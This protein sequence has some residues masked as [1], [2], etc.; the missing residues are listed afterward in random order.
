MNRSGKAPSWVHQNH[1]SAGW[2]TWPDRIEVAAP[3][4]LLTLATVFASLDGEPASTYWLAALAAAW[5][6]LTDTLGRAR[7]PGGRLLPLV[8]FGGILVIASVLMTH[9]ILFLVFMI[10][11]FFH[12]LRLEPRWLRLAGLVITAFLL[13]GLANGGLPKALTTMPHVFLTVVLVQSLTIWGGSVMADKIADQN[14]ARKQALA[15]LNAAMAENAGLHRQLLVQA[16]EA[17]VLDERQRLS[18]EIHDTLA[19]G[20]AGII[21]Q[22]QAA[23]QADPA[24]WRRHVDAALALARENL[25]EA[26]R[27]VHALAPEALDAAQLPDALRG[28]ARRWSDRTGVPIEFTTTGNSRPV[29]PEIEA[30]LL[31]ITQEALS[32][33][34]KHAGAGRVGLTLSYMEEQVTLD[35]RDDGSGFDTSMLPPDGGM[36][37]GFGIAGMRHRAQ[38]LAG[39][40]TVEAEPGGGTAV[41]VNLPAIPVGSAL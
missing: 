30:T 37:G 22:L 31:R 38:R 23:D 17:G 2:G 19:Q 26:R 8:S 4:V 10:I 39:T 25:T 20:F 15:E 1:A 24:V 33:V 14:N 41:S 40:L 5:V 32:N 12:A 7:W 9:D 13:H 3:Y 11:G 27:S 6:A 34:A 35:V 21:T 28:V 18:R 36:G 16:R 29:H